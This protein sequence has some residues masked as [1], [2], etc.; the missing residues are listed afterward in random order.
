M[1]EEPRGSQLVLVSVSSDVV[2]KRRREA[3]AEVVRQ[4]AV[5]VSDKFAAAH[6]VLPLNPELSGYMRTLLHISD[7]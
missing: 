2:L 4:D 5:A 7:E 6:Q 3:A 1:D